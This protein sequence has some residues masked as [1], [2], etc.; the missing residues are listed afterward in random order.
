MQATEFKIKISIGKG[1]L[2]L[3]NLFNGDRAL[4]EVV[5]NAINNNFDVFIHELQPIIEK[6]LSE[7]FHEIG[8]N[9]LTP[10]TFDQLFPN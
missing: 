9:I 8:N 5:N 4:G 7:A 3:E 1:S 6:A 10:F 2:Q